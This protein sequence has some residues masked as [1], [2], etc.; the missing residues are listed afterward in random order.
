MRRLYSIEIIRFT[1]VTHCLQISWDE[2]GHEDSIIV[3]GTY[4][5]SWYVFPYLIFYF[6][7]ALSVSLIVNHSFSLFAF[8]TQANN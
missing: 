2:L 5:L 4:S 7:H 1:S 3:P 8:P 6:I